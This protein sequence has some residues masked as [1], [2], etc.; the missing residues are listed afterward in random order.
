MSGLT[1][2]LTSRPVLLT[3]SCLFSR[4]ELRLTGPGQGQAGQQMT[5][6]TLNV[7]GLQVAD[8]MQIRQRDIL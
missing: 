1:T 2:P 3:S 5:G 8:E 6:R 7:F 4:F